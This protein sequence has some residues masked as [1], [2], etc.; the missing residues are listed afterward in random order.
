MKRRTF[1]VSLTPVVA[2]LPRIAAF[3]DQAHEFEVHYTV[4]G[5]RARLELSVASGRPGDPIGVRLLVTNVSSEPKFLPL[6]NFKS[7]A[8]LEVR[9]D[10]HVLAPDTPGRFLPGTA[11]RNVPLQPGETGIA[12]GGNGAPYAD[13]WDLGYTL[14]QPG[15]YTLRAS[16]A[17]AVDERGKPLQTNDVVFTRLA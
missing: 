7:V 8:R 17:M 1:I 4:T 15:I 13:V 5:F 10:G 6:Y 9:R 14:G 2:L 16:L 12:G 3:A 11:S